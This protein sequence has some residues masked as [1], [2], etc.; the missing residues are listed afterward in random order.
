LAEFGSPPLRFVATSAS[1][2]ASNRDEFFNRPAARMGWWTPPGDAPALADALQE[3][4]TLQASARESLAA[5][6]RHHV[7]AQFSL[8][9]M[10]DDTL[11]VY[12]ALL[13]RENTVK[14]V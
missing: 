7:E 3:A 4:L 11:A 6:A 1:R 8:E 9:K 2:D 10:T 5:R 14:P 12:Q 13:L